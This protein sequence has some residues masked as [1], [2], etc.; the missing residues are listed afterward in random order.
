M[1]GTDERE[2]FCERVQRIVERFCTQNGARDEA[3]HSA[4]F[5]D[6]LWALIQERGLPSPETASAGGPVGEM[7]KRDVAELTARVLASV[8]GGEV[9]ADAAKQIVKA[10]FYPEFRVCRDS[11]RERSS[12]GVCKRQVLEKARGRVSGSH[13]VD[14]PYWTDVSPERHAALLA[15]SW[16]GDA[17][18]FAANRA[19]FLPEDFRA[20]RTWVRE[21]ARRGR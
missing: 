15:E 7:D 9:L 20:L 8:S 12:K 4:R 19:V 5:A 18:E 6:A 16:C 2:E 3:R 13:C 21:A 11:Y 1:T 10:C 14:C 17:A